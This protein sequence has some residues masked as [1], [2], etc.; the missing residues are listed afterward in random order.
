MGS[1]LCTFET[2][3]TNVDTWCCDGRKRDHVVDNATDKAG[4]AVDAVDSNDYYDY[5][6]YP[7]SPPKLYRS[8]GCSNENF[9]DLENLENLESAR[10]FNA[11][12]A[13]LNHSKPEE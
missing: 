4:H 2:Y 3:C 11:F 8:V 5:S 12:H 7:P 6:S 10:K 1:V 9:I 13:S